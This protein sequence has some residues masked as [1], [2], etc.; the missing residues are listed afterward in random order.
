MSLKRRYVLIFASLA[1]IGFI[2]A[3]TAAVAFADDIPGVALPPSPVQGYLDNSNGSGVNI[4][5]VYSFSMRVGGRFHAVLNA[6]SSTDGDFDLQLFAPGTMGVSDTTPLVDVD[7]N[8]LESYP[9][10]LDYTATAAGL[11][12]LNVCI[13]PTFATPADVSG[14][15]SVTWTCVSPT[16]TA[17]ATRSH[18][19]KAGSRMSVKGSF[20]YA[21]GRDA[22]ASAT[23]RLESSTNDKK[24][25]TA[26]TT[27]TSAS[28]VF[29][30]KVKVKRSGYY[31]A[32]F[33]GTSSL[34]AS[35]SLAIHVKIR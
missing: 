28:G 18:T 20:K 32:M 1:C 31:R 34:I 7:T 6:D 14:A 30:L 19:V 26:T 10:T 17:L 35:K 25:K 16:I 27:T 11:Y 4:N 22:I 29:T 2:M 9:K 12:Y 24:W 3:A 33:A 5:D 13:G 8:S 23:I 15:Y 21:I